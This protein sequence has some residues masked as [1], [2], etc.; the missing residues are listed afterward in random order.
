VRPLLH[1]TLPVEAGV[2]ARVVADALGHESFKTTAR[3]CARPEAIASARQK[4]VFTV[5]AGGKTSR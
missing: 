5:P 3:S 2:T 4:R 1:S